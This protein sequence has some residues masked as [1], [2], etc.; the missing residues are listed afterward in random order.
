MSVIP[1][2]EDP[3]TSEKTKSIIDQFNRDGWIHL[4]GVLTR[5]DIAALTHAEQSPARQSG[6]L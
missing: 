3:F 5:D 6:K 1:A 2:K 4:P